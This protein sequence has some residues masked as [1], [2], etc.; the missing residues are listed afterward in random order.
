MNIFPDSSNTVTYNNVDYCILHSCG[1]GPSKKA[2]L[3]CPKNAPFQTVFAFYPIN[4]TPDI[5]QKFHN[6]I[7]LINHAYAS[8]PQN[9][10]L[11][12]LFTCT[13]ENVI[14][15]KYTPHTRYLYQFLYD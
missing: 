1:L 13:T 9:S 3:A 8:F 2:F 10:K 4:H 11:V 5:L 6:D 15:T 14:I 7:K 12:P